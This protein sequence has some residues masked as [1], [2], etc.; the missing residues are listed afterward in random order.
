MRYPPICCELRDQLGLSHAQ[1]KFVQKPPASPSHNDL[2]LVHYYADLPRGTVD[3]TLIIKTASGAVASV[4]ELPY[5]HLNGER[6]I[7][8]RN[9]TTG[10]VMVQYCYR[11]NT[12]LLLLQRLIALTRHSAAI[13]V[14]N[15][16]VRSMLNI[17]DQ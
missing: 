15:A 9:L 11:D 4:L 2:S 13:I 6:I 10:G 7:V 5:H 17:P 3:P 8:H 14:S 1:H 12:A 16:S